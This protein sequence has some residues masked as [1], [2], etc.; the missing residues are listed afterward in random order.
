M[1]ASEIQQSLIKTDFPAFPDRD[2][3]DLYALYKP[4]RVVSGDLF[5]YFFTDD[6]NLV[7]TIG[8]VSGKG[9][10]AAIFM[11]IAQTIIRNNASFKKA[12]N[13]V[14]KS[15]HDLCT[16]KQPA[17]PG[18]GRKVLCFQSFAT[19]VLSDQSGAGE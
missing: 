13:I 16:N 9:V 6:E 11:S 10:P 18:T 12:K 8:D 7:F 3:V 14:S 4:A 5:D 19:P 1:Q 2:D 15:N 17:R